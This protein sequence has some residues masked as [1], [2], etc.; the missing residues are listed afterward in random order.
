MTMYLY[1]IKY[2][3]SQALSE[4]NKFTLCFWKK[5]LP[6]FM[7]TMNLFQETVKHFCKQSFVGL[8]EKN[9]SHPLKQNN[10]LHQ[11]CNKE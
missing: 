1:L 2:Q 10:K 11:F 3:C 6:N 9:I 7:E 8:S 5:L 4:K